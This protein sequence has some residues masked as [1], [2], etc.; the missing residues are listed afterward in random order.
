MKLNE[1]SLES[2]YDVTIY[3]KTVGL[4]STASRHGIFL[5]HSVLHSL[6]ADSTGLP[7]SN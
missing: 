2:N 1:K 5:G 3:K 7:K 4:N 6:R